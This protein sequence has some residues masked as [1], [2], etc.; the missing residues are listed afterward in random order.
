M[1][2]EPENHKGFACVTR[3]EQR[4]LPLGEKEGEGEREKQ[5]RQQQQL[6]P[7]IPNTFCDVEGSHVNFR[8]DVR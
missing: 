6:L 4:P 3:L 1:Y 7:P 5:Q 2:R 8:P